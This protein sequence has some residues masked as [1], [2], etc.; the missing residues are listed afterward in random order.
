[1][2][3][4]EGMRHALSVVFIGVSQISLLSAEEGARAENRIS[5]EFRPIE[6]K[7]VVETGKVL[8]EFSYIGG[9]RSWTKVPKGSIIHTP[10]R[11]K[12]A[13]GKQK[14]KFVSWEEFYRQN[15]GMIHLH[16]V[17]IAQA[18]GLESLDAE[19]IEAYQALG[20]IVIAVWGNSII[21]VM[22]DALI[23]EEDIETIK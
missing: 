2:R 1:M 15:R 7:D 8:I 16:K 22:E 17:T 10:E 20:R 12:A 4:W 13:I 3:F 11:F 21:S 6:K 23:P 19:T 9:Q 5:G 14:G 18:R